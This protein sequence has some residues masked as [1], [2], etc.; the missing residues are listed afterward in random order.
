MKKRLIVFLIFAS[1]CFF[2]NAQSIISIGPM[3]HF[4]IGNKTV[5]TSF[6]VELAFW[7]FSQS[8]PYGCDIGIEHQKSKWRIYSEVQTGLVF[9]GISA[10]PCLEIRKDSCC[11][12]FLQTSV[13]ANAFLGMDMRFRFGKG[14]RYFS[15][16]LYAKLPFPPNGLK[17]FNE[18]YAEKHHTE[19]SS[20]SHFHWP[21]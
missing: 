17:S 12:M 16:G 5:K 3:V 1:Y 6:G 11:K 10:G 9:G 7:D 4:N 15:P 13:W 19:N 21:D 14:E 18:E 20:S 2:C 8:L